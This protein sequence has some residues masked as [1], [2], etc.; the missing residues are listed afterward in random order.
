M[1]RRS[2]EGVDN[3]DRAERIMTSHFGNAA[4]VNI[5]VE[6]GLLEYSYSVLV[7]FFKPSP[8]TTTI[9]GL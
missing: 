1:L 5:I 8:I 9:I 4:R 6:S 7:F 3:N 2:L